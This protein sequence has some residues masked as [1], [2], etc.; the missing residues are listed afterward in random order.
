MDANQEALWF[1]KSSGVPAYMAAHPQGA[2]IWHELHTL[3]PKIK[4]VQPV[5][6][7]L[8]YWSGNILW[9]GEHIAAIVDWEEAAYGDPAVDVAYC[10]MEMVLEGLDDAADTFLSIYEAATGK[11]VANLGFWE[12]AAAV[13]PMTDLEGWLT[14]PG[15][16]ERFSQFIINAQKRAGL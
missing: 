12:L 6:I 7:H 3:R 8:D 14:Q 15:M 10:R 1:L 4:P 13:R 11:S 16:D 9:N 2:E 5:L